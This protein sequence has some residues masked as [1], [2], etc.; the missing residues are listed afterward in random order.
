MQD[1]DYDRTIESLHVQFLKKSNINVLQTI[2]VEDF[3][4]VENMLLVPNSGTISYLHDGKQYT[5]SPGDILCIPGGKLITITYGSG[6]PVN[7]DN[8]YFSDNQGQYFETTLE[9]TTNRTTDSFSYIRFDAKVFGSINFFSSLDIPPFVIQDDKKLKD[10]LQRIISES[11]VIQADDDKDKVVNTATG[12]L[13]IQIAEHVINNDMFVQ[14]LIANSDYF[15]DPRLLKIFK[16]VKENLGGDLSNRA[17]ATVVHLSEDY[18]GQYFKMLTSISLQGYIEYQRME[19]AVRLLR[20]SKK[21]VREIGKEV[22][23]K[24][25]THFCQRFKMMFGITAGKMRRRERLM[26]M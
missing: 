23:F 10:I 11:S 18:V 21:R 15:N 26:S 7:L 25:T 6:A 19:K 3:F 16:Y 14:E 4:D 20:T 13:V 24:D 1:Y 9:V 17:L 12:E 22:G 5:L 8:D 2:T